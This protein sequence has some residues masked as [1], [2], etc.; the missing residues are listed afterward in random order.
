VQERGLQQDPI[1]LHGQA[2][3]SHN[4]RANPD[5]QR[6][7]RTQEIRNF[8]IDTEGTCD[9]RGALLIILFHPSGTARNGH[10][11]AVFVFL[12]HVLPPDWRDIPFY[13][14][15]IPKGRYIYHHRWI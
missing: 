11:D 6:E 15:S 12:S 9:M 1:S 5:P 4:Y 8:L 13:L 2:R 10:L 14:K 3:S 7:K